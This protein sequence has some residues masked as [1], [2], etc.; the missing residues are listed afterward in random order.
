MQ[1]N[2]ARDILFADPADTFSQFCDEIDDLQSS[3]SKVFSQA[4]DKLID[5]EYSVLDG[6][7]P[8]TDIES[9]RAET[10]AAIRDFLDRYAP[11]KEAPDAA[12]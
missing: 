5:I 1:L 11:E 10:A 12:S 3:I 7:N 8:E 2:D 6:S 4:T 9:V